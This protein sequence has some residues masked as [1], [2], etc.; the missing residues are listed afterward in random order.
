MN[1]FWL[2]F[3]VGTVTG[4]LL[5]LLLAIVVATSGGQLLEV[6]L[7]VPDTVELGQPFEAR[8]T[9]RNTWQEDVQF[10]SVDVDDAL[11]EAF[12]VEGMDPEPTD[13]MSLPILDQY[14]WFFERD[15]EPDGSIEVWFYLVAVTAGQ[16]VGKFEVCNAAQDC[17]AVVATVFVTGSV[18]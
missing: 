7:H 8:L 2:G 12:D 9:I 4:A 15:L 16:H 18:P 17:A 1:R 13:S 5:M 3:A 14:S 10:H 11:L 6:A